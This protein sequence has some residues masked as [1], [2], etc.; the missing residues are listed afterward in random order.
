MIRTQTLQKINP[1][2][3]GSFK[4]NKNNEKRNPTEILCPACPCEFP[5]PPHT[6]S[7][8]TLMSGAVQYNYLHL[9][10]RKES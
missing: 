7:R 5:I 10:L 2:V 3:G 1:Q 9:R 8:T 4:D 6:L